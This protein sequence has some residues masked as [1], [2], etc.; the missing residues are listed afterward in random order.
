MSVLYPGV[1][2]LLNL[3]EI[4]IKKR[5]EGQLGQ[6]TI[7]DYKNRFIAKGLL[8]IPAEN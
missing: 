8:N 3:T 1:V 4:P 5:C 2:S 7:L 6:I